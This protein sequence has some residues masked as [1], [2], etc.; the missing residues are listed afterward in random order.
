M[1]MAPDCAFS[2]SSVSTEM[3]VDEATSPRSM[4]AYAVGDGEKKAMR[5]GLV[6]RIGNER[7][8]RVFVVG[9]NFAGIAGLA[10][11]HIQHGPSA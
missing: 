10:E 1:S 4:S 6:A 8:H 5:A 11:H 7:S 3:A 9:S 2:N